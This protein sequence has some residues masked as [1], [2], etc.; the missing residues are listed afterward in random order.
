MMDANDNPW[1]VLKDVM[2][3]LG[4]GNP[5]E[6]VRS[7]DE[8]EFSN[9]ELIDSLGRKQNSYIVSEAGLYSLILRS[10]KSEARKFKRWITHEVL[11]QIRRTGGYVPAAESESETLARAVLIAQ[12]TIELQREQLKAQEHKVLF[13]DAVSA[14]DGTCLVGELA[15]MLTQAGFTIGQNKLFCTAA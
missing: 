11:P 6:T 12:K 14:S 5:S 2:H 13:A 7:L 9:T 3:V 8:D 15:K 1:F 4:L 10:R